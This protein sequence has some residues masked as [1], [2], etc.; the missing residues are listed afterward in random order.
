VAP[1]HLRDRLIAL[2]DACAKAAAAGKRSRIRIKV[3][4]L[5]DVA[6]IDA[7][8]A[9]SDRGVEVDVVARGICSLRPRVDGLSNRIRVRSVLG[10]FLEHS[11]VFIFEA[12]DDATFLL[13]SADL[14]P[15]N[16]DH[17]IEIVVPVEDARARMDLARGFDV[18]LADNTMAWELRADGSWK[19]LS[20]KKGERRR[21]AQSTFIRSARARASRRPIRPVAENP[22]T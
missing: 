3:N 21:A 9:A 18:L 5:T 1:F 10:R 14:M 17:R 11:R 15:R 16:L 4:S 8:Y 19:R 6:I 13:G 7:L 2:I 12:G 20:S 22:A